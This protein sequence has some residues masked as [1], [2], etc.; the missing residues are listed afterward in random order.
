MATISTPELNAAAQ[1]ETRNAKRALEV[2]SP[3]TSPRQCEHPR[4]RR[5]NRKSPT[6]TSKVSLLPSFDT[7]KPKGAITITAVTA[8]AQNPATSVT[9][10][11]SNSQ[12]PPAPAAAVASSGAAVPSTASKP[13]ES[14]LDSV[15]G[16][17]KTK[18]QKKTKFTVFLPSHTGISHL[19]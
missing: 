8:R 5:D 17:K 14:K 1:P 13:A 6:G 10:A 4:K 2:E 7:Q 15:S 18:A 19:P 9:T 3:Q 11:E 16:K 12:V